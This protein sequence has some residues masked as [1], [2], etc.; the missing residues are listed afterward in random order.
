MSFQIP[1]SKRI[2][3]AKTPDK[4]S[5]ASP[6]NIIKKQNQS[7]TPPGNPISFL[8]IPHSLNLPNAEHSSTMT[9]PSIPKLKKIP[10]I[11]PANVSVLTTQMENP[12]ISSSYW[13][14]TIDELTARIKN[15]DQ[16]LANLI[17]LNAPYS[18]A[19]VN[20]ALIDRSENYDN[21]IATLL[22][23]I[24]NA[25]EKLS[26]TKAMVDIER[27]YLDYDDEKEYKI[28]KDP[29][30]TEMFDVYTD[31]QRDIDGT[32]EGGEESNQ[33]ASFDTSNSETTVS[34]HV[35]SE[36]DAAIQD[37]NV[38]LSM[39]SSYGTISDPDLL[40]S[41]HSIISILYKTRKELQE[42]HDQMISS[43][44]FI[45]DNWD[46]WLYLATKD[47]ALSNDEKDEAI[48][49]QAALISAC[50]DSTGKIYWQIP[51]DKK[52]DIME[53]QYLSGLL[54]NRTNPGSALMAGFM[55]LPILG[56]LVDLTF[57]SVKSEDFLSYYENEEFINAVS[58]NDALADVYTDS[59]TAYKIGN[60]LG[61][62]A[63]AYL[64]K[65]ITGSSS[66]STLVQTLSSS[67]K[68][69]VVDSL[70]S[71]IMEGLE[72]AFELKW[73]EEDWYAEELAKKEI[74]EEYVIQPFSVLN[75]ILAIARTTIHAGLEDLLKSTLKQILTP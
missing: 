50:T 32:D 22:S 21:D 37:I 71:G 10:N 42:L 6:V 11:P 15:L 75:N 5:G 27:L 52:T 39:I 58:N 7:K 13:Q 14:A 3:K 61:N 69:N 51:E 56:K 35:A 54:S 16:K 1:D 23:Q 46:R 55:D 73:N 24:S 29:A 63:L 47:E 38:Q 20:D 57:S 33:N 72:Y 30:G 41:T 36:I 4:K 74:D 60:I 48:L 66:S 45:E 25:E 31:A 53:Y 28:S 68:S 34:Y 17:D 2:E 40:L 49:A 70:T 65:E 26:E 19:F 8:S 64:A 12:P 44:N 59:P 67:T 43:E 9:P 62:L 18:S